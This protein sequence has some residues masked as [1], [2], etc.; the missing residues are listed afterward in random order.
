VFANVFASVFASVWEK[1]MARFVSGSPAALGLAAGVAA[2]L[3]AGALWGLTFIAPLFAAPFT[4]FDLTVMR[5][6]IYGVA[7]LVL[8]GLSGFAALRALPL[9]D[10]GLFV[11]LGLSG[12]VLYFLLMALAVPLAGTA[13]VA[14]VVGTLPLWIGLAGNRGPNRVPLARLAGPLALVAL[15]L[16]LV[17]GLAV[18]GMPDIADRWRFAQGLALAAAAT[19]LWT[20]FAL[21]N[22]AAMRKRPSIST[23]DWTLLN[24]IGVLIGTLGLFLIGHVAGWS[25]L[26]ELG[27]LAEGAAR[28]WLVA[29]VLGLLSSFGAMWLWTFTTRRLPVALSGQLIVSE[30]LF[31]LLFGYLFFWRLPTIAEALGI[32]LMIAGVIAAVRVFSRRDPD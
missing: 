5:Y 29:V 1:A 13:V 18:L 3:A 22:A 27:P 20:L 11:W 10:V 16:V 31:A 26:T 32:T 28:F 8:L 7:S 17:K 30:T 9:R 24:G 12:N 6:G 15:G 21:Q 4:I 23:N 19:A 25:R 2:G 14:L